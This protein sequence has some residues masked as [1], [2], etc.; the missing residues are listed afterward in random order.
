[1][2]CLRPEPWQRRRGSAAESL[3]L[4]LGLLKWMR[5][6]RPP[7][8]CEFRECVGLAEEGEAV[9]AYLQMGLVLLRMCSTETMTETQTAVAAALIDQGA[10]MHAKD[11]FGRMPLYLAHQNGNA[12]VVNASLG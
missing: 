3:R 5:A 4:C 8:S 11:S 6:Q 9:E 10:G 7:C 2:A 12:E 1:M